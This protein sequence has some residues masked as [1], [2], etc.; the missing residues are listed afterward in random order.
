MFCININF[1]VLFFRQ[2]NDSF[3][4]LEQYIWWSYIIVKI[5]RWDFLKRHYWLWICS[6][7]QFGLI[8]VSIIKGGLCNRWIIP[9][10][11]SYLYLL[12]LYSC[13]LVWHFICEKNLGFFGL[14]FVPKGSLVSQV[15][16]ITGWTAPRL[17]AMSWEVFSLTSCL[18]VQLQRGSL[19]IYFWYT[20]GLLW[21][22]SFLFI[23]HRR[24]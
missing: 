3:I 24:R 1:L 19:G 15:S 10:K 18:V 16:N 17:G 21:C 8:L 13:N 5:L 11:N 2:P 9:R 7:L 23:L 20:T 6:D 14:L 12:L 22:L 4:F